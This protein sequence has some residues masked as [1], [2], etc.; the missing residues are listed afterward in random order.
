VPARAPASLG[1]GLPSGAYDAD[2]EPVDGAG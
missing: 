2:V 1:S